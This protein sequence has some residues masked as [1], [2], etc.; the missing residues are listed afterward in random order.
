MQTRLVVAIFAPLVI[1]AAAARP[2][3]PPQ[4][5]FQ[6]VWA[7]DGVPCRSPDEFML[8]YDKRE[9]R[10]PFRGTLEPDRVCRILSVGSERP[11]WILRLSCTHP[12]PVYRLARPFVLHQKLRVSDD[13]ARMTVETGPALGQPARRE[14]A[15]Y[16]RKPGENPPPLQCMSGDGKLIDC[17]P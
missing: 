4:K 7:G 13:G 1:T 16:C 8:I 14:E 12:D 5:D 10:F 6:G 9:A 15:I 17:P 3:V 2:Y 11:F